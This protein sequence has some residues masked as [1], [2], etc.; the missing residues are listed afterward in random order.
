MI[1]DAVALLHGARS[2]KSVK[3]SLS[4]K[5]NKFRVCTQSLSQYLRIEFLLVKTIFAA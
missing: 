5:R 4:R 2:G 1:T 3:L